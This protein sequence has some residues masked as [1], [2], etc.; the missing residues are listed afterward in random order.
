MA[1]PCSVSTAPSLGTR[2]RTCPYEASTS[3]S[4][5]R[6]FLIVRA[7][8]GD[9]TMTRFSLIRVAAERASMR[10]ARVGSGHPRLEPLERQILPRLTREHHEHHP[11]QLLGIEFIAVER[12]HAINDDFALQGLQHAQALEGEEKAAAFGRETCALAFGEHAHRAAALVDGGIEQRAL[13]HAGKLCKPVERSLD[14]LVCKA[15]ARQGTRQ[16]RA[17]GH[18]GCLIEH[19]AI[20]YVD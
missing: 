14:A 11:L 2:S 18:F 20:K 9:S 4:L 17:L 12:D 15:D 19:V 13:A 16:R 6:Y 3:K 7:L 8:A 5:P 1:N 10:A